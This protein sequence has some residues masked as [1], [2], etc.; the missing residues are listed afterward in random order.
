MH[1][2]EV[3][4][5]RIQHDVFL[6]D[7]SYLSNTHA[8]PP[9]A[10]EVRVIVKLLVELVGMYIRMTPLLTLREFDLMSC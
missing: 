8:T 7:S 9:H 10:L 1:K 5:L 4:D 2:I 3:G 6:V